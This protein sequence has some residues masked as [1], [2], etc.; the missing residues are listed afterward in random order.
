M[1]N[2]TPYGTRAVGFVPQCATYGFVQ[3]FCF[4]FRCALLRN[5]YRLT[6]YSSVSF[7]RFIA[8]MA[9]VRSGVGGSIWNLYVSQF[10][11]GAVCSVGPYGLPFSKKTE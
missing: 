8:W 5:N 4:V 1:V 3:L 2:R 9:S 7:Q 6:R 11:K 10:S